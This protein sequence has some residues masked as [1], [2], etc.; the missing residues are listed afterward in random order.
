M[1]HTGEL[2]AH[3]ATRQPRTIPASR[4]P[5]AKRRALSAMVALSQASLPLTPKAMTAGCRPR[6]AKPLSKPPMFQETVT[7]SVTANSKPDAK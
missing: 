1:I 5:R 4:S 2:G 3:R 6:C 7:E